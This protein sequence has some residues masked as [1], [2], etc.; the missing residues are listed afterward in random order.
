MFC[1]LDADYIIEGEKPV[2]RLFGVDESGKAVIVKD[3]FRP[4]FYALPKN[5]ALLEKKL[6]AMDN[7]TEIKYIKRKIGGDEKSVMQVF[8]DLP[9]NL[10]GV[11]DEIKRIAD[12]YE[13]SI[14]FYKRYLIDKNFYPLDWITDKTEKIEKDDNP[15]MKILAF[16]IETVDDRIV[17]I[18][19]ADNTGFEKVITSK[20]EKSILEEFEETILKTDPHI[21][22]TYN[23]D[24]FDFEVL[25]ERADYN[26]IE[27]KLGDEAFKFARRAHA[28]SARIFGRVHIDLFNFV[29]NIL[30]P[31]LQSEILTLNEVSRELVGEGKEELSLEEIINLWKNN[32]KKLAEYCQNDSRL[33]LKLANMLLPQIFE[34]AKLSGQL[35]FD[36]SRLT[37]GLL[38]EWYLI[39]KANEMNIIAPNQ[40]HWNEIQ[41]RRE[42]KPYKG[43]YVI[44]PKQGLHDNIAIF[45]F[46]SLYPSIIVSFNI[47]PE[48]LNCSCC[49][50]NR[51]KVPGMDY[52]FC[53][54][55]EGFIPKQVKKLIEKRQEIKERMKKAGK[56][57][58]KSLDEQQRAVK[59][60]ANATYGYL[61]YPGSRWYSRECSESAAAF[62]RDSIK[63]TISE[64]EKFGF[65]VLYGDTD[66]LFVKM[67]GK[68][69][70]R[71]SEKFLEKINKSLPGM[72]EL[73]MQGIYEKGLFV[74]QRL[75]N[76]VA[77][78]RYAL[79]DKKGTLTIRGLETVRRDWCKIARSLQRDVIRLVLTGKEK[80]AIKEV[81]EAV[82]RVK[83]RKVSLSELMVTTQL[84][85]ALSDYKAIGPHVAVAKKLEKEGHEIREGMLISFII[86]KGHGSISE[87]AEPIDK[88][89]INDY[90]ID[91]YLNNQIISVALRVLQVFGY[92]EEDFLEAGMKKFYKTK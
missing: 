80:K 11:R 65:D 86:T 54:R 90:D 15:K 29:Y 91:Y 41:K 64:A 35:P 85:K 9:Q 12:C 21:I 37:Y 60:I 50:S 10:Q 55:N 83:A 16:D 25:R 92:K 47:S 59:I 66:S 75:G 26:K 19:I 63:R 7:V 24:K 89:T 34:L 56:E 13:Y 58:I 28:N 2:I 39:R 67:K 49:K 6:K 72:I 71:E 87:R 78:K 43:G 51:Y 69:V 3:E 45:D 52:Y 4:Y 18:S 5:K 1:L 27:L 38:V 20:D 84:G 8:V 62:G 36:C 82:K 77:K 53:K 57:E 14:N 23:G 30:S 46:R 61:A 70:G 74:P 42:L 48:T 79:I 88:V 76:Y 32:S 31:Q 73:E 44:E 40:P 22:V 17:M 81:R 68:D 33:T